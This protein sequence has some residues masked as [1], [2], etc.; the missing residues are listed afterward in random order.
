MRPLRAVVHDCDPWCLVYCRRS[1]NV[2]GIGVAVGMGG[3]GMNQ[4]K[5]K[6]DRREE[7]KVQR[8]V[9]MNHMYGSVYEV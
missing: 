3:V 2:Y 4:S 6:K 5:R 7:I 9:K 8:G 1:I